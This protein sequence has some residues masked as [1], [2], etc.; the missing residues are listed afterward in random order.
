VENALRF[1]DHPYDL[2]PVPAKTPDLINKAP[3]KKAQVIYSRLR[4]I[5][6]KNFLTSIVYS[7][8]KRHIFNHTSEAFEFLAG[9]PSESDIQD[10]CFQKALFVAK[11]SKSFYDNGVIFV[12]AQVP[13]AQMHAWVI[14]GDYQYDY[15]D[16][17]WV[18]YTPLLA[19][20]Y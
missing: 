14:E 2:T 18:N 17:V 8:F 12:G 4:K 1:V 20:T 6:N 10:N 13:T 19:I 16:R 5:S 11:T 9:L 15:S 7:S 3:N